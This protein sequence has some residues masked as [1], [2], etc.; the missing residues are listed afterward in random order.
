M[1]EASRLERPKETM[2][3]LREAWMGEAR[4]LERPRAK[5]GQW[6]GMASGI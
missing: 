5:R 4:R 3:S 2:E 6:E 1:G